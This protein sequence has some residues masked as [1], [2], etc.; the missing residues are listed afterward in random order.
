M[1]LLRTLIKSVKIMRRKIRLSSWIRMKRFNKKKSLPIRIKIK[2]I[3]WKR[4][5]DFIRFT[6]HMIFIII[7]RDFG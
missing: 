3:N 5:F 2:K 7:L 4:I 6:L 1:L